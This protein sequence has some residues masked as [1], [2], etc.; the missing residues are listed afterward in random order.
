MPLFG[1]AGANA[2]G[3]AEALPVG[4]Y[5]MAHRDVAAERSSF[6]LTKMSS[7][8]PFSE[9]AVHVAFAADERYLLPLSVAARSLCENFHARRPLHLHVALCGPVHED[10]L[11]RFQDTIA[12]FRVVLELISVPERGLLGLNT[13][14]HF[15]P[16]VYAR[17]LLP[18]LLPGL[19]K[20]LYLDSDLIVLE[21][22]SRL[23]DLEMGNTALLAAPDGMGSLDHPFARLPSALLERLGI[24][25][26]ATMYNSGVLLMDL[27][28]WRSEELS[29]HTL[30]FARKHPEAL[31]LVDQ[32][33]INLVLR[34]RIGELNPRW[35]KQFTHKKIRTGE[36]MLPTRILPWDPP[37]ILH[38]VSEEKPWLPGCELP[39]AEL[40]R[41]YWKRTKWPLQSG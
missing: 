19:K 24:P 12:E 40:F 33:A 13:G 30:E 1:A 34:G 22:I 28:K 14:L 6:S 15:T 31:H 11:A 25:G 35:N 27:E 9:A 39:E 4:E 20:V 5:Y 41:A 23:F 2:L 21:N 37:H 17:L 7:L 3:S 32:N 26:S 16:A 18:R 10:S 8:W 29:E 38:F 36:W